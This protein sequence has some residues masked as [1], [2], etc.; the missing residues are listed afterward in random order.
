MKKALLL[1]P[2]VLKADVEAEV[3]AGE[4]PVMDYYALARALRERHGMTVD[5]LDY[6]AAQA[7]L[8]GGARLARRTGGPDAALA[9]MG[10]Q[11]RRE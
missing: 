8:S 3:A 1:I 7:D 5:L 10:F 2:S 4:H 9:L 6:A 11:R